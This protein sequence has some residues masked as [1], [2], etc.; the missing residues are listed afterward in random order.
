VANRSGPEALE[1][2][3]G[4]LNIVMQKDVL[5]NPSCHLVP[6][7]LRGNEMKQLFSAQSS[8]SVE[9]ESP[10]KLSKEEFIQKVSN[11]ELSP[12]KAIAKLAE[13]LHEYEK[14]YNLRSEIFYKLIVGT[15]AEDFPDFITWAMCYRSYFRMLQLRFSI[16]EVGVGVV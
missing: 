8:T 6:T 12:D 4:C 1:G 7:P 10:M 14:K 16:E 3:A 15:P 13:Q 9:R 2:V 11:L 5:P